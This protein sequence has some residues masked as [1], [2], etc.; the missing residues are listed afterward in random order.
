[1]LAW[2]D[3]Y[4]DL[5]MYT[6]HCRRERDSDPMHGDPHHRTTS[7][8]KPVRMGYSANRAVIGTALIV[9]GGVV[10]KW[11]HRDPWVVWILPTI[12]IGYGVTVVMDKL[13]LALSVRSIRKSEARG[14]A[15]VL[16][17]AVEAGAGHHAGE[18]ADLSQLGNL[19]YG[20]HFTAQPEHPG[21]GIAGT[22]PNGSM[23]SFD[24]V[25]TTDRA[26]EK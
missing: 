8:I 23:G 5:M 4:S 18:S 14:R 25:Y 26:E 12:A 13:I 7:T 19:P 20:Q 22:L 21:S 9:L 3:S 11:T 10:S 6:V 2:V 1:M 16:Y 24:S 15:N 17:S